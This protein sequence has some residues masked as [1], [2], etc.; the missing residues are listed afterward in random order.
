MGQEE[1]MTEAVGQI[2]AI[3]AEDATPPAAGRATIETTT[4]PPNDTGAME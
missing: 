3:L 1:G 2:D 4:R